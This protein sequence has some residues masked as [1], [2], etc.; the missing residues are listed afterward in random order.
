MQSTPEMSAA[1]MNLVTEKE[2]QN[3]KCQ[4]KDNKTS[5]KSYYAEAAV[6]GKPTGSKGIS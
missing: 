4:V 1:E 2:K 3:K 5:L 6:A